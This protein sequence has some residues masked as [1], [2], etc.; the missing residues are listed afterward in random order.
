LR[1]AC[2]Q[3]SKQNNAKEFFGD[4]VSISSSIWPYGVD[5][6]ITSYILW[7]IRLMQV[8]QDVVAVEGVAVGASS[9]SKTSQVLYLK[10]VVR[11]GPA[12]T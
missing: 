6:N 7:L 11:L 3:G 4:T 9:P 1:I 12:R 2:F 5:C 10:K 8:V